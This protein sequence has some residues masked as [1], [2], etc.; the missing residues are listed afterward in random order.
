MEGGQFG[1]V[2]CVVC[3]MIELSENFYEN[4]CWKC[5]MSMTLFGLIISSFSVFKIRTL[6]VT[7]R[8]IVMKATNKTV[9]SANNH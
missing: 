2:L 5:E 3:Y 9:F 4:L 6:V 1:I 8:N 7:T